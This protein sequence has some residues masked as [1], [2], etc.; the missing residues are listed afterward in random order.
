M[1]TGIAIAATQSAMST[2]IF[3][4]VSFRVLLGAPM[5][6]GLFGCAS[7]APQFPVDGTRGD[8]ERLSGD[9]QGEYVGDRDHG[10]HGSIAFRL[11][12]GEEHAHGTVLMIPAGSDRPYQA[13]HGDEFGRLT[14]RPERS[15]RLLEIQFVN[16][17]G[18]SV[19]GVL[20]PYWDPDH[21]TRASATFR[22]QL[23]DDTIE[24]SFTTTYANGSP[25]TRGRWSVRRRR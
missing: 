8:L 16:A 9:W 1:A 12:A 13:Y 14:Q 15:S 22:G 20:A 11:I 3:L 18:G 25:L 6:A 17:A 10:R 19:T 7:L 24:G 5:L 21:Q 4:G 2:R 23:T